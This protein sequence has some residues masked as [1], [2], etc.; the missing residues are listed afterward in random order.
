MIAGCSGGG[1]GTTSNV[2]PQPPPANNAPTISGSPATQVTEGQP[3]SFTP[4]AGDV[5]GDTLT[6]SITQQP[7]WASFDM[8]TGALTGTPDDTNIGTTTGVTVSVS[9]GTDTASLAPFDLEVLQIQLGTATVSWDTPTT[10][11]DG[12]NLTDLDGFYVHYGRASGNYTRT[13]PVNDEM[14]TS[15]L[16]EDLEPGTWYFVVTAFDLAG[17]ESA[18]SIEVSKAVTL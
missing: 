10:N 15:V 18:V 2:T 17:N 14:A 11:A 7:S 13:E 1:A 3:Y 12:S 9:D 16:I 5:D 6:F 4:A 8:S